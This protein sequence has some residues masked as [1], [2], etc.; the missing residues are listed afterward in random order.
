MIVTKLIVEKHKAFLINNINR[1]EM[2]P[3]KLATVLTSSN[4]SGKTTLLKQLSCLPGNKADFIQGGY[5][6]KNIE[7]RGSS[8]QLIS[9]YE[10]KHGEHHFIK[11]G[12]ELNIGGTLTVQK[13]LVESELAYTAQIHDLLTG[14]V[15][16]TGMSVAKRREWLTE[17]NPVN[18]DYVS[19]VHKQLRIKHRDV[20]GAIKINSTRLSKE[21]AK[22]LDDVSINDLEC[23]ATE[24]NNRLSKLH[25][26]RE[27]PEVPQQRLVLNKINED[28]ALV[29]R[30]TEQLHSFKRVY[31]PV[32]NMTNISDIDEYGAAKR[33]ENNKLSAIK[34]LKLDDI[35]SLSAALDNVNSAG[36][37][38]LDSLRSQVVNFKDA[39]ASEIARKKALFIQAPT[40]N[41]VAE[42]EGIREVLVQLSSALVSTP[43]PKLNK[44]TVLAAKQSI[45]SLQR[46]QT[47]VSNKV[48]RLVDR[49]DHAKATDHLECPDCKHVW[50]PII[51][52][53]Q[54]KDA[55]EE[56]EAVKAKLTTI[57]DTI[58]TL[59]EQ[60]AEY[61]DYVALFKDYMAIRNNYRAHTMLWGHIA[62]NNI[63][64]E[65]PA[66]LVW[67][68]NTW[69]EEVTA[70]NEL[71][72][73]LVDL[74]RLEDKVFRLE[75]V[76]KGEGANYYNT[77]LSSLYAE[78]DEINIVITA[79][80]KALS[81][82]ID[83]RRA[84]TKYISIAEDITGAAERVQANYELYYRSII[85]DG[86][87]E[88]INDVQGILAT[89]RAALNAKDIVLGIIADIEG[90]LT[91]LN[92]T[93][94][95]YKLLLKAINPGDG[96][97]AKQMSSF[98]DSLTKHINLYISKVWT[99]PLEVLPCDINKGDLSYKF[100]VRVKNE[101]SCVPD[102]ARCSRG[103]CEMIDLAFVLVVM[104]YKGLHDY[105]L[106][107]DE[108]GSSFDVAH[109]T[110][111]MV[112]LED[113]LSS[114]HISQLFMVNHFAAELTGLFKSLDVVVLD[115]SNI[116]VPETSN[117]SISIT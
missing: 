61:G 16:F 95:A 14:Q 12:K 58:T 103:Q 3:T 10:S 70:A 39:I 40:S 93:A 57:D 7:H 29:T 114:G 91:E 76:E 78:V 105:P 45:V 81:K 71:R 96:L 59:G 113:L 79:A 48:D 6:E 100:P 80:D 104:E 116:T 66:K 109:R 50:N 24:L 72:I 5:V 106:F 89:T 51:S 13:D 18:L 85:K 87:T 1:I 42:A 73:W 69:V 112:F 64:I 25:D 56:L 35:K 2:T 27:G 55:N 32:R 84:M 90:N 8:Y 44:D 82:V 15:T 62:D 88:E 17:L 26:L 9:D 117:E 97:I 43:S 21:S 49:I 36:E 28:T 68:A 83:Y 22:V 65:N 34:Q 86:M 75:A 20:V 41:M 47:Q 107:S 38:D 31:A 110:N 98:L 33:A 99:Y 74:T 53:Q 37:Y 52:D 60:I 46:D 19:K 101:E 115:S 67:L 4:G 77:R 54:L 108:G 23:R 111:L 102:I 92:E 63:L 11:D 30:L 94:E